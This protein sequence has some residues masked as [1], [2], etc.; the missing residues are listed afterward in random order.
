MFSHVINEELKKRDPKMAV[1]FQRDYREFCRTR[2]STT[3]FGDLD[4]VKSYFF[5]LFSNKPDAFHR[6]LRCVTGNNHCA[7]W[8]EDFRNV[9]ADT[10][11]R[12]YDSLAVSSKGSSDL[13]TSELGELIAYC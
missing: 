5:A 10:Y 3:N 6:E 7:T 1:K 2:S 9:V 4:S 8:L 11:I 13:I 12:H